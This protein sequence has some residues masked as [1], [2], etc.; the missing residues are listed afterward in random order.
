MNYIPGKNFPGSDSFEFRGNDGKD[1]S[2]VATIYI[3]G[4]DLRPKE[5]VATAKRKKPSRPKVI[6]TDVELACLS[7]DDL[8]ID[9]QSIWREA[10]KLPFSKKVKV[11]ILTGPRYGS[12]KKSGLAI[13]VDSFMLVLTQT[14]FQG[15][16]ATAFEEAH[17]LGMFTV[18]WCY[19]RNSAFKKDGAIT[20]VEQK[21]HLDGG[22]YTSFGIITT[23]YAGSMVPTLYR[24]PN[25]KYKGHRV[26]TNLPANGAFRGHGCPQPRF[27][28]ESLLSMSVWGNRKFN[29]RNQRRRN[30]I[31]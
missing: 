6:A 26:Y 8:E 14:I 20:A 9:W 12:L 17:K 22:A 13:L 7:T 3:S 23:Y 31:P 24:L 29:R 15:L 10:N 11:E 18:L 16:H 19:L 1:F 25:Y 5:K 28:F 21:V 27:A 30:L 4:P 2:Q